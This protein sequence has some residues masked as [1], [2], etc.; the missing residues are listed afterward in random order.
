MGIS[1]PYKVTLFYLTLPYFTLLYFKLQIMENTPTLVHSVQTYSLTFY[2]ENFKFIKRV[3][4]YDVDF[5]AT[6]FESGDKD[7]YA[8]IKQ[9]SFKDVI[10]VIDLKTKHSV[11]KKVVST[12]KLP[13][14]PDHRLYGPLKRELIGQNHGHEPDLKCEFIN[15][16]KTYPKKQWTLL[17]HGDIDSDS[18]KIL[19][20]DE[21]CKTYR[22]R[23]VEEFVIK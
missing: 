11:I 8:I 6:T 7:Y 18:S 4:G 12:W 10:D 3:P 16:L 22:C 19:E 14:S 23:E 1:L 20:Y 21:Y 2:S 13:I 5:Y 9:I 15:Y 17:R